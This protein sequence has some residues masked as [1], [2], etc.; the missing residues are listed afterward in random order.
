MFFYNP[1]Q[2][3]IDFTYSFLVQQLTKNIL[4][5][6]IY[7]IKY[8]IVF[9]LCFFLIFF[10]L[11]F[12]F[13]YFSSIEIFSIFIIKQWF[14]IFGTIIF[15]FGLFF[16]VLKLPFFTLQFQTCFT[17]RNELF[18][19]SFHIGQLKVLFLQSFGFSFY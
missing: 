2:E 16:I 1:N 13:Y 8:I 7:D 17:F 5:P 6:M 3:F 11:L 18:N 15:L 12:F 9:K 10:S 14:W 4:R 19:I